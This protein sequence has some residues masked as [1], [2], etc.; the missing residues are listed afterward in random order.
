MPESGADPQTLSQL[1]D[2]LGD[3][4]GSASDAELQPLELESGEILF[5][6][7]QEA[8]S[9]YV[10]TAGILG[11][12]VRIEDG[13]ETDID[14]LAPGAIVG[15]MALLSGQKRSATVYAVNRAAVIRLS[16]EKFEE[17]TTADRDGHAVLEAVAAPR[18]QR[19]QLVRALKSI[20]G[21]LE[22]ASLHAIQ[23]QITWQHHSNGSLIF[24]QGDQA[25][26][27][28]VVVNG[29][30]QLSVSTAEGARQ[31]I[32]EIGAGETVGE[33][34]LLSS[35]AR[36][37]NVTAVRETDL[38]KITP[39]AFRRL[40]VDHPG[41]LEQIARI[42]VER[43]QRF[44]KGVRHRATSAQTFTL[45][46][47]SPNV[48]TALFTEQLAGALSLDGTTTALTSQLFDDRFGKPGTSRTALDGASS[49][50]I[51]AWLGELEASH[52][53]VIY[54][55]DSEPSPWT[56][57]CVGQADRILLLGD[58]L[59]DPDPGDLE[60]VL[61]GLEVPIRCELVLWHP[62]G[63]VSPQGT[64][65]W[66]DPRHLHA[67]HHLEQGNSAHMS[68]LARRISG[69]AVAL[70]LSG[71]GARGFSQLGV[72]R[73]MEELDIPIDYVCGTSFGALMAGLLALGL[74]YDSLIDLADA[75][76]SSR[77]IFDY[78]LPFTSLMA[79]R[80]V[81][82][83]CQQVFGERL[84]EDLWCPF[85]CIS[86]NLSLAEP[87]IH[88]RGL[89]WRAV[90]ASLSIPGV[91]APVIEGDQVLVDGGVMDNFPV[92]TM[93]A[94]SESER[95]IAVHASPHQDR[96]RQWDYDTSISGWRILAQRINP[97]RRPLRSPSLVSTIL[98]TQEINS[99]HR[100]KSSASLA[101]LLLQM[102]VR[103][104][105]FLDFGSY[106]AIARAGYETAVEPLREWKEGRLSR[107]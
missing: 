51:A 39:S 12:R 60:Q 54:A 105:G 48:D 34:A 100:S 27:M 10:L 42:I 13:S 69:H 70:V 87:R 104:F 18:W 35:D 103:E 47:L 97:L 46:P 9:M 74:G 101:D 76:A 17:L 25:D 14:R 102:D 95:V 21:E 36:S 92:E 78:T 31:V 23:R 57:R 61:D 55:A 71:G 11:V 86:S 20:F 93:A 40:I 19:L 72:Y 26:G 66:L 53:F 2:A 80:K 5:E 37:A 81:T 62:A 8:D 45:L 82:R 63:T 16:K 43:R 29:R 28:Y 79:S 99:A 22:P 84:I 44:L 59:Q 1:I 3:L 38:A 58:P 77:N 98:R 85:F 4:S 49:P 64:E 56:K 106:R 24:R 88:Q 32:G 75:F 91:F 15:E 52:D 30:L 83:I 6:Q 89:L 107:D 50:A 33:F 67:H 73:A 65:A 7:G 96:T 68:R 94:L 90:R 41:L